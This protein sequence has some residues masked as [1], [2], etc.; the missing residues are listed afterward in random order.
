MNQKVVTGG[1]IVHNNK[2]LLMKRS[3]NDSFLPGS[4]E[5]PGGK[6]EYMEDP[7]SGASREI[8]EEAGLD[9]K[10]GSPLAVWMYEN[11]G[12]DTHYVQIDFL[13]EVIGSYDVQLSEEHSDFAW[14]SFD[15]MKNYNI[16]EQMLE[17]LKKIETH[18]L[19]KELITS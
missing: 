6:L 12:R 19:V 13:C 11:T 7:I 4:W 17:E 10:I 1:F 16:S 5:I 8:K 3:D 18:T 2:F 9:V 14:I 15:E